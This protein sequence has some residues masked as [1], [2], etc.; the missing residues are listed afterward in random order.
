MENTGAI[1]GILGTLAGALVGALVAARATMSASRDEARAS[2]NLHWLPKQLE[3]LTAVSTNGSEQVIAFSN[4]L[5]DYESFISTQREAASSGQPVVVN[6]QRPAESLER[7]RVAT[8]KWRSL[9]AERLLYADSALQESM[10]QFDL[11]RA[12]VVPFLLL[13]SRDGFRTYSEDLAA[14]RHDA[15]R[16]RAVRHNVGR[17]EQK[18]V[19][20]LVSD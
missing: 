9:L 10:T 20:S 7:T 4:A 18:S 13:L 3:Y 17:R 11:V 19:N 16:P 8:D 5:S 14:V 2:H 12:A 15:E 6:Y 1:L